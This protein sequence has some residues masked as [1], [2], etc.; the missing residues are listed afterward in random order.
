MD[1]RRY[2]DIVGELGPKPWELVRFNETLPYLIKP[3][4]LLDAGCGEGYWLK[5]L[6]EITKFNL[7]GCDVSPVRLD[8]AKKNLSGSGI[9]LSVADIRS[10][11]Y[12][13]NQFDQVTALEVLEH[14]PNWEK[15][16]AEIVRVASQRAV[17]T[18]PY[19]ETLKSR[20]CKTCGERAY[21]YGHI[22]RFSEDDFSSSNL[23]GKI[24]FGYIEHPSTFGDYTRRFIKG[25]SRASKADFTKQK[26][27]QKGLAAICPNCYTEVNSNYYAQRI[28]HRFLNLVLGYPS[29]LVVKIDK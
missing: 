16:L 2:Y 1:C 24:S 23:D 26:S 15:G 10:L 6:S 25:I 9:V 20:K 3:G 7:A 14:V 27:Q 19:K 13:D 29:F 11:P 21:L 8:S 12:H 17:I 18:V 5:F 4:T 28:L 22:N